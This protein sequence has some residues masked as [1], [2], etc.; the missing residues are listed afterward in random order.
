[1]SMRR[2]R[3][4][5]R[6][7][8][9]RPKRVRLVGRRRQD[10][11]VANAA[12]LMA[13][14]RAGVWAAFAAGLLLGSAHVAPAAAQ[15]RGGAAATTFTVRIENVAR[16]V[17][18]LPNGAVADIPLSPGVWAVHTA[19][20]PIFT[21]GELQSGAGLKGLAEAGMAAAFA[22]NLRGLPGVRAAG[23]FETPQG[24][25]RG[26]MTTNRSEGGGVHTTR[27]LQAGQHFEFTV[28]AQPGDRL[29]LALM[30]AQSNDGLVATG[31]AGIALF[32]GS[33]RPLSGDITAAFSLWDVGTE[34][35]EEPGVGRNQG[36][37]QG[38]PH[39]GDPERRPVR[40][41]VEAEYGDRWPP[42]E[43]IVKVTIR[44]GRP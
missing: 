13:G 32:D 17:L 21:P 4:D 35:N 36:L 40:P 23:A 24:R 16:R 15:A 3:F 31:G 42:V 27:M 7:A 8:P 39:A 10:A 25:A 19:G 6:A 11:E 18:P 5:P 33:G 22:P 34:V 37:R 30:L 26:S 38:A 1:M 9:R 28:T 14:A 2:G 20:N 12:V 43:R 44:P 29:S 41:L